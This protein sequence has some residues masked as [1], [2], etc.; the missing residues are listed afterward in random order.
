MH[1]PLALGAADQWIHP[2]KVEVGGTRPQLLEGQALVGYSAFPHD[3]DMA[4]TLTLPEMD[5]LHLGASR[6]R[7]LSAER[8]LLYRSVKKEIPLAS[9]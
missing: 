9:I 5:R 1:L 3:F 7:S 4:P 2:R 8:H 6:I